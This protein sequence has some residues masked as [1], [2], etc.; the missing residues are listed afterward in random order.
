CPLAKGPRALPAMSSVEQAR[1]C[2]PGLGN[3]DA[4]QEDRRPRRRKRTA[5]HRGRRGARGPAVG[6]VSIAAS[7]A[8][9]TVSDVSYRLTSTETL[10]TAPSAALIRLNNR[11]LGVHNG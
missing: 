2:A 6:R 7:A 8:T 5:A 4:G 3:R 9:I 1:S 11:W 10:R